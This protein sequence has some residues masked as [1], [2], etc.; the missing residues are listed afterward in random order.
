MPLTNRQPGIV[1]SLVATESLYA[2]SNVCKF[3][4][5]AGFVSK[6][7]LERHERFE[8]GPVLKFEHTREGFCSLVDRIRTYVPLE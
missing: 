5:T 3:T 2:G 7:I 6:A 8:A 1:G 4:H